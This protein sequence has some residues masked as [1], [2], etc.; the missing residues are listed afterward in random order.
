MQK[1]IPSMFDFRSAARSAGLGIFLLSGLLI[2][3][4]GNTALANENSTEQSPGGSNDFKQ[5]PLPSEVKRVASWAVESRDNGRN[6]RRLPFAI[7]DKVNAK[8]FVF[9]ANGKLLGGA[10]ALLGI[11]RGDHY[12]SDTGS[13]NMGSIKP[14]DRNTP[15]G[16]FNVSLQRDLNG[17]EVLLI[18]YEAAI[19][20]HPV[21]KGTPV[22]RRAER[23][24]SNTAEDNRISYGCI[25]VPEQF[26]QEVV[27]PAFTNT[28]GVVYILPEKSSVPEFFGFPA[29]ASSP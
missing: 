26:Y 12:D 6:S 23:L 29:E 5:D 11:G 24:N 7:I 10:P 15:A 4:A 20:L 2:L 22:E 17:K 27:S 1:R 16:R 9:D 8:V 3:S 21:V 28:N 14:E 25:N 18:D 19:A 13:Q